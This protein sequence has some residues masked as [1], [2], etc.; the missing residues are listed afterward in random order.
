SVFVLQ[1]ITQLTLWADPADETPDKTW[2]SPNQKITLYARAFDTF[3]GESSQIPPES[4]QIEPCALILME[5]KKMT[6]IGVV[7]Y[8]NSA[9][10]TDA[11][12]APDSKNVLLLIRI[13]RWGGKIGVLNVKEGTVEMSGIDVLEKIEGQV[14]EKNGDTDDRHLKKAWFCSWQWT[15]NST[16]EGTLRCSKGAPYLL[17]L[18]LTLKEGVPHIALID[19]RIL[20]KEEESQWWVN[21][22]RSVKTRPY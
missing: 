3:I 15:S 8:D 7:N 12:W 17:K 21:Y 19:S 5:G 20:T 9:H 4:W 22:R 11:I 18:G 10:E 13:G 2:V 6:C 1:C 14:F 16:A